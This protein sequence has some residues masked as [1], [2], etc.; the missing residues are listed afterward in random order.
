[1][2]LVD[3]IKQKLQVTWTLGVQKWY[4]FLPKGRNIIKKQLCTYQRI[5]VADASQYPL[6]RV[7]KG[8]ILSNLIGLLK[9]TNTKDM[10]QLHTLWFQM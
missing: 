2:E 8:R 4:D 9:Q 5:W 7:L 6:F 10:E 3:T 1:M